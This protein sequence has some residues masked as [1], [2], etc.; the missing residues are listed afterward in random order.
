MRL[1]G[2]LASFNRK[3]AENLDAAGT[4]TQLNR[5][6]RRVRTALVVMTVL[7]GLFG[8]AIGIAVLLEKN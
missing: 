3:E 2:R 1:R 7:L 6:K 8:L 4:P 5:W